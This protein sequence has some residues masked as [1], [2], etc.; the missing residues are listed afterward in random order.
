MEETMTKCYLLPLVLLLLSYN[1]W[2]DGVQPMGAGTTADPYQIASLDNLLWMSTTPDCW[3]SHFIQTNDIDA[4]LS[5]SMQ[6]QPIGFVAYA[7]YYFCYPDTALFTGHYDGQDYAID[8]LYFEATDINNY[9]GFFSGIDNAHIEN[10]HITNATFISQYPGGITGYARNSEISNCSFSGETPVVAGIAYIACN[11]T[12]FGCVNYGNTGVAG[13]C[14]RNQQSRVTNCI[15]EGVIS[16]PS[17]VAGGIVGWNVSGSIVTN[18]VNNGLLTSASTFGGIVGE[19]DGSIISNCINNSIVPSANEAGGIC[20]FSHNYATITNCVNNAEIGGEWTVGG[21]VGVIHNSNVSLCTNHGNLTSTGGGIVGTVFSSSRISHCVNTGNFD[22]VYSSGIVGNCFSSD[23]IEFTNNHYNYASVLFDGCNMYTIG[24]LE[25]ALFQDWISNDKRLNIDNYFERSG[26]EYVISSLD[27]LKTMLAFS[28]SDYKFILV[29]NLDLSD[30]P[31][32]FIPYFS[33]S[34][35]GNGHSISNLNLSSSNRSN[36][37]LFG[38]LYNA[39]VERLAVDNIQIQGNSN[40]G[41]ISGFTNNTTIRNC[42]VN[43]SIGGWRYIGGLVGKNGGE[44]TYCYSKCQVNGDMY[45]GGLIGSD[46]SGNVMQSFWDVIS[47]G[48][49]A[50]DGGIGLTTAEMRTLSTYLD[51]G[52]DFVNETDNGTEDIW[53]MNYMINNGYPFLTTEAVVA[54]IENGIL[55]SLGKDILIGNY[56]N[57]FNPETTIKFS[58]SKSSDVD[59]SIYN[60][61]G[62]RV[63]TLANQQYPSGEHSIVWNGSDDTGRSVGS[64]IYFYKLCV[65]GQVVST[66]KCILLK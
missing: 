58:I 37:G 8:S 20:G 25:D 46:N 36:I 24:A 49:T 33:G 42:H 6:I 59:L 57:P 55:Q 14:A 17:W 38:I 53:D 31:E 34:F 62:Q 39:T 4:S 12:I 28:Q 61:K 63:C 54:N 5:H 35:N 9:G 29:C 32:F 21:I 43:G 64:G 65:D 47:S 18:C 50:S 2:A 13:I 16:G 48:Q 10:L 40:L 41:G 56:P 27:D 60:I 52:W 30:E 19:N 7:S 51:A 1:I 44:I 26:D 3:S 11:S 45:L 23:D 15:N 22:S 66:K